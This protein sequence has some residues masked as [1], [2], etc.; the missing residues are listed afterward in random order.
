MNLTMLLLSHRDQS[1]SHPG[2]VAHDT[3][4]I[5][6]KRLLADFRTWLDE[7]VPLPQAAEAS[8]YGSRRRISR[9][10]VCFID[11]LYYRPPQCGGIL[12]RGS[13]QGGYEERSTESSRSKPPN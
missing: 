3:V 9:G 10:K 7:I 6:L 11:Q 8:F 13:G 1:S 4:P 2:R 12:S 5:A